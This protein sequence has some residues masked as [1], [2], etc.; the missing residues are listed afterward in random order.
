MI[1]SLVAF[2][3]SL[4]ALALSILGWRASNRVRN[5][6]VARLKAERARA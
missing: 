3:L 2:A 6:V 1:Q 4:V 5:G